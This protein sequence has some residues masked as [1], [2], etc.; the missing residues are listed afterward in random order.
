[1]F[2]FLRKWDYVGWSVNLYQLK[3]MGS[4]AQT[5]CLASNPTYSLNIIA[6]TEKEVQPNPNASVPTEACTL[7]ALRALDCLW[8]LCLYNG[9]RPVHHSS[10]GCSSPLSSSCTMSFCKAVGPTRYT[11]GGAQLCTSHC[12]AVILGSTAVH[13]LAARLRSTRALPVA[14]GSA[15]NMSRTCPARGLRTL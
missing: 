13:G 15:C 2:F 11:Q 10:T 8:R 3:Y 9:R 12:I 6:L 14:E 4:K 7:R 1:V 5:C